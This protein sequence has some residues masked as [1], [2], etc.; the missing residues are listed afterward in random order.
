M[1]TVYKLV[2]LRFGI[3]C[4]TDM[5]KNLLAM[6]HRVTISGSNFPTVN[7]MATASRFDWD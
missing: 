1:A 6:E 7:H 5:S 3:I 2:A 4:K